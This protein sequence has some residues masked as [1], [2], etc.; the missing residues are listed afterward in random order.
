M[1]SRPCIGPSTG[2]L[3]ATGLQSS[4][5]GAGSVLEGGGG[6][7]SEWKLWCPAQGEGELHSVLEH[8]CWGGVVPG[9]NHFTEGAGGAQV[10]EG[11]LCPLPKK[12]MCLSLTVLS[13]MDRLPTQNGHSPS[14]R[15]CGGPP[16]N[17]RSPASGHRPSQLWRRTSSFRRLGPSTVSHS[18]HHRTQH[19]EPQLGVSLL[20]VVTGSLACV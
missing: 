12:G 8:C 1:G 11:R 18:S 15:F 7:S 4:L 2:P 3:I 19:C 6:A 10:A 17:P 5:G 20:L 13:L 16:P 14:V 9:N